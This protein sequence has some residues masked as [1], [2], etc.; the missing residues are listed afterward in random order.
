MNTPKKTALG[1]LGVAAT[2]A[3]IGGASMP[4]MADDTTQSWSS[5]TT[6]TKTRILGDLGL[7]NE[8]PVIVNPN[9]ETGDVHTGDIL[10]GVG[11]ANEVGNGNVVG[12]GNDSAIG[13]GNTTGIDGI[14][15][16]VSD[17][18]DSSV[19]DV[20]GSVSD[21]LGDLD[22]GLTGMFED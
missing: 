8:S 19:G 12:S 6:T 13:S 10:S 14:D 4:A 3:L 17:V 11:S 22:L 18:V 15:T 16:H 7:S 20:T 5:D 1:I 21:L 2:A 9:V